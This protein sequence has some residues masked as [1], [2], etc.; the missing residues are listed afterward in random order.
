MIIYFIICGLI[1]SVVLTY[2]S[3]IYSLKFDVLAHPS[4]RCAH[5]VPT[6]RG[7][8]LAIAITLLAM[9]M[10][11]GFAGLMNWQEIFTIALPGGL[12]AA[13]GFTDDHRPVQIS[14]RLFIHFAAASLAVMLLPSLPTISFGALIISSPIILYPVMVIGLVWLLNLYNFM[15][16]ID[17]IASSEAISILLSA[18]VILHFTNDAYWSQI[19]LW[20]CAP[21]VGFLIWNWPPA[22][23]FMGDVGS[24]F[25]GIVIGIL[26]LLTSADSSLTLWSWLILLAVFIGDAAWS[27][28]VRITTGQAWHQ[29]H[30]SHAYQILA[31]KKQSHAVVSLGVVVINIGWLAPLAWLATIHPHYGWALTFL[32]YLPI[33]YICWINSAGLLLET[34]SVNTV[35]KKDF[36][37]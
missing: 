4:N 31:R 5:S 17:G 35:V 28:L 7:G 37:E 36:H 8:G 3:C 1:A 9:L 34:T 11:A 6:P 30:S 15:D 10:Y 14:H 12:V 29:P 21:I 26:A 18:A 22:K 13:I 2:L 24:G 16:G 19:L 32:A 20:T 23:I 25:I 27:L 33:L